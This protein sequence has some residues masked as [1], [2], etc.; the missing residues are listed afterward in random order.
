MQLF[1]F[2]DKTVSS[3]ASW[4]QNHQNDNDDDDDN[5]DGNDDDEAEHSLSVLQ[6]AY[7]KENM[8]DGE[9]TRSFSD[10]VLEYNE[11]VRY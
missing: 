6:L 1:H 3:L 5:D 9:Y 8:S 11:T 2:L 4:K 7:W 10:P